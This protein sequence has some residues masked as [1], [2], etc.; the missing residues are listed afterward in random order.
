VI[1]WFFSCCGA[2]AL[3]GLCL[4]SGDLR[5]RF[6]GSGDRRIS[7]RGRLDQQ[8]KEIVA[9]RKQIADCPHCTPPEFPTSEELIVADAL[10]GPGANVPAVADTTNEWTNLRDTP[11][12][13]PEHLL[14]ALVEQDPEATQ[15]LGVAALREAAQMDSGQTA[16]LPAVA[17]VTPVVPLHEA[18]LPPVT[19]GRIKDADTTAIEAALGIP[20]PDPLHSATSIPEGIGDLAHDKVSA[21]MSEAS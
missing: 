19:W 2:I 15:A 9:L 6:I 5:D 20:G 13:D 3:L 14:T 7:R 11:A 17:P 10:A 16:T 21:A 8:R 4:T 1:G 18:P 12:E